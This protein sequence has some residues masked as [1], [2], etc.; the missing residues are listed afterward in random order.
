MALSLNFIR[1]A[2]RLEEG[3]RDASPIQQDAGEP[4]KL[5][6][7]CRRKIPVS[8]LW[9]DKLVCTCGYHF[10]MKA[11]QRIRMLADKGDRKSVV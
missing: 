7:N 1:S 4:E 8:R 2:N 3:G 5:C 6:P 9:G 11:R 10:H